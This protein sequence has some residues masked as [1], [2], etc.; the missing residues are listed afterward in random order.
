MGGGGGD[1]TPLLDTVSLQHRIS[2]ASSCYYNSGCNPFI[3]GLHLFLLNGMDSERIQDL[4][5]DISLLQAQGAV[6]KL[7][8]GGEEWGNPGA[9]SHIPNSYSQTVDDIARAVRELD[10]D[11]VDL[12]MEEGCGTANFVCSDQTSTHLYLLQKLREE[13]PDK[14]R[15]KKRE[16]L[17][18]CALVSYCSESCG[19]LMRPKTSLSKKTNNLIIGQN[20]QPVYCVVVYVQ[21]NL[22]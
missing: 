9:L 18:Y 19:N 21:H 12:A 14:V 22:Y 5:D 4:R 2:T 10:A 3:C 16:S 13:L 20:C 11:G 17:C 15:Q 6:V 7:A 1:G 8:F